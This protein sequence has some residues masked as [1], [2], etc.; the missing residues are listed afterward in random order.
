MQNFHTDL[1]LEAGERL[2]QTEL[3]GLV[4]ENY[5]KGALQVS[6]ISLFSKETA[7]LFGKE[8]GRYYTVECGEMRFM[9]EAEKEELISES[10]ALLSKLLEKGEGTTKKLIA[11]A[12]E[13]GI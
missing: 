13:S 5:R 8:C 10:A 7:A 1:A 2:Q 9:E 3:P 6:E 11:M 4:S 12:N